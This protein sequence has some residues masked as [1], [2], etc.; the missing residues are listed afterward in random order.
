M[1][2]NA[3][4]MNSLLAGDHLGV[5]DEPRQGAR[6]AS[7][8]LIAGLEEADVVCSESVEVA[9]NREVEAGHG[10]VALH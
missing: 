4:A 3:V 5:V 8:A 7:R 10:R 2:L 1:S 6:V 9:L